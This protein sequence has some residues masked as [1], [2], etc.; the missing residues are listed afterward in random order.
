LS[1]CFVVGA[2]FLDGAI[3]WATM[4]FAGLCAIVFAMQ[5]APNSAYLE[6]RD[7]GFTFANL[8][9]AH[10]VRW[11]EVSQFGIV[12]VGFNRMVAWNHVTPG[13][14]QLSRGLSGYE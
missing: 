8:W 3:R 5:L 12:R 14:G 2:L 6:L 4:I 10:T 13:R 1:L 11:N 7:D 9:R